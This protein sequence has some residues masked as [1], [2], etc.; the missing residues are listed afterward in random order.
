MIKIEFDNSKC[1]DPLG[2]RKCL[3]A[4]PH[5]VFVTY[6]N[7]KR[8]PGIIPSNWVVA[9]SFWRLCTGCK[10]CENVCPSNALEV[11]ITEQSAA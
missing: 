3:N 11:V 7:E 8:G 6:P 4:C 2:C 9:P 1:L 10:V 5:G